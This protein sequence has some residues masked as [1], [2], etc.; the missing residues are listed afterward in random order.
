MRGGEGKRTPFDRLRMTGP[1]LLFCFEISNCFC[2]VVFFDGA[3][4]P[5]YNL[6]GGCERAFA[7]VEA[8]YFAY[9]LINFTEGVVALFFY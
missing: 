2:G 4:D 6:A 1:Q 3:K 5:V 9:R 8:D 7:E